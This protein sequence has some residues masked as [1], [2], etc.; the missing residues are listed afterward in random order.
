[1]IMDYNSQLLEMFQNMSALE[2]KVFAFVL[3]AVC[4]L[5][6]VA[7]WLIFIKA[8]EKG[9]K[10]LIPLYRTYLL[11]KI[12]DGNGW[13]FLLLLIPFVNIVYVILLNIRLAK[14][15]GK[16]GLFALGLLLVPNLFT[17]ILGFG[18]AQYIAPRGE[19]HKLGA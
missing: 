4:L 5:L 13:K 2:Q 14:A 3:C 15:F 9:W 7:E 18:K 6:V 8:G 16:G 10:S 1:M 17:L 19:A 12:A 11:V